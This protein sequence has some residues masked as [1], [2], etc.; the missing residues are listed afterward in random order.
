MT[1]L[2]DEDQVKD[3]LKLFVG[4]KVGED[5]SVS[6]SYEICGVSQYMVYNCVYYFDTCYIRTYG[7]IRFLD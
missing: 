6:A 4:Y 5:I 7:H 2:S 1:P 3:V